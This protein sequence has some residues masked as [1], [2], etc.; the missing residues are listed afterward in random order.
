M[1]YLLSTLLCANSRVDFFPYLLDEHAQIYALSVETYAAE[2][3][4]CLSLR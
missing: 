4:L 2:K 1:L 3:R